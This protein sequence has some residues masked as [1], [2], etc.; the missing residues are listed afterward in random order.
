MVAKFDRVRVFQQFHRT[1]G[2]ISLQN[3]SSIAG[4]QA[5]I[6]GGKVRVQFKVIQNDGRG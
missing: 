2:V 3:K 6:G 4:S 1:L 5:R